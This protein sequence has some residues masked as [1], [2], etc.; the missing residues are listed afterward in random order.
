MCI[1]LGKWLGWHAREVPG[2]RA[3]PLH[4]QE[5][6]LHS[7]AE[8][9]GDAYPLYPMHA[10]DVLQYVE[11]FVYLISR[12]YSFRG[13][14]VREDHCPRSIFRLFEVESTSLAA[15]PIGTI[16]SLRPFPRTRASPASISTSRIFNVTSSAARRPCSIQQFKYGPIPDG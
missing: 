4:D 8:A 16:R 13:R 9:H 3:A 7:N 12:L 11:Q 1:Y 2:R 14:A 5:D 6:E 15:E 10:P